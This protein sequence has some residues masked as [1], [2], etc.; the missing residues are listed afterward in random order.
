MAKSLWKNDA[1]QFP[2]LLAEIRAIGLT[3]EQY[4][5]LMEEMDLIPTEIDELLERAETEWQAHKARFFKTKRI[6]AGAKTT[7]A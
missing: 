4:G 3:Q 5:K 1:V 6:L 7:K 2:R